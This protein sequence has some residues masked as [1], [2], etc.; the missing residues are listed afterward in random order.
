MKTFVSFDFTE[1]LWDM[2][3]SPDLSSCDSFVWGWTK[4]DV[5]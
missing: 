1:M 4:E 3:E 2:D 5:Y